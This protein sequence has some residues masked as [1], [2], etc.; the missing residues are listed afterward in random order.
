VSLFQDLSDWKPTGPA[1][2]A[3]AALLVAAWLVY[4]PGL[5]GNFLFDDW[6]NLPPLGAFGP[7]DN[8]HTLVTYLLSG[9]ASATGRPMAMLSFLIDANNWP[10]SPE[11]FKYTNVMIE[12][13]NG[14]LLAWMMFNVVTI[15]GTD[16]RRAAWAAVLGAGIWLLHPLMVSTTLFVVQRMAMLAATFV[17]VGLLCYVH[18]RRRLAQGLTRSG[19]LWMSAGVG[20]CTPLAALSKENG[21]LLPL[22][23]L[24]LEQI[25]FQH[26]TSSV[27][28]EHSPRGWRLWKLGFLFLPLICLG[29]Y[30]LVQLPSMLNGYATARNFT[31]G[32]RLLTEGRV[33]ARYIYVLLVPR[34]YT[35]GLFNDGLTVSRSLF[36][37]WDTA[38]CILALLAL[39]TLGWRV[40][41]REPL[42]SF[43]VLFYLAGQLLESTFIPLE[44]YYE[45][46]NYL[47]AIF[48]PLPLAVW[49]VTTQRL[50]RRFRAGIGVTA[51]CLLGVLTWTRASLWGHPFQQAVVWARENPQSPRAQTFLALHLM[52]R[53]DY[54]TA[55]IVL[56]HASEA[57]PDNIMVA[58]NLLSAQCHLGGVTDSQLGRTL[59]TLAHTNI[60]SRVTYNV[61]ARFIRHY[62]NNACPGL[63]AGTLKEMIAAA[64]RNPRV[65]AHSAQVQDMLSLRGE[66]ILTEG[67]PRQALTFF[68]RALAA[69][70]TPDTA[71]YEAARLGSAGYPN[72]GIALLNY[73]ETLHPSRPHGLNVRHLKTLWLDHLGYYS[74]EVA[75][76]RRTLQAD[77]TKEKA[78]NLPDRGKQQDMRLGAR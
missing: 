33:V 26:S 23:A 73:W 67:R 21:A 47:P 39:L 40:R 11:P 55:A 75:R 35:A 68:R 29:A 43:A 44:L 58:L 78:S 3:L 66:L 52:N 53:N 13:L 61:I 4:A 51:L 62:Q 49:L 6:V 48:L 19:Y 76:L 7:V 54:A 2:M 17:L 50:T 31:L 10:A 16:R 28:L 56:Q 14:A 45:H 42:L 15:L 71:L 36:Q 22:F 77:A 74:H 8:W 46:R 41:R 63:R 69:H 34:A 18:G 37:P 25:V 64:L 27:K 72:T 59:R 30:L 20:L 12:L 38:P 32:E 65:R 9:I 24:V 60:G 5:S 1:A 70:P 57:H